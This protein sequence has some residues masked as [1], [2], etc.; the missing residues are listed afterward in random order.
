MGV[1][2]KLESEESKNQEVGSIPVLI[3]KK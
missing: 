2:E 1:E 3:D